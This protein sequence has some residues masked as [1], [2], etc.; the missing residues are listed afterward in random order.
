MLCSQFHQSRQEQNGRTVRLLPCRNWHCEYCQ[1]NRLRQLRAM[2]ASGAPTSCLTLTINVATG[3][4]IVDRYRLLHNAWKILV[5]RILREF[6]KPAENRWILVTDD[7]YSY[8]QPQD[9]RNTKATKAGSIHR[10]HYM[11]FPEETEN[12]QPHLHILLRTKYI[13]QRWIAQQMKDLINSPIVWIEKIKGPAGAIAYVTKY[14][15]TAP[16]Q[17]GKS[18]RYWCSRFYQIIG[19]DRLVEPLYTRINSTTIKM[20]FSELVRSIVIKG[21]IALPQS[22]KELRILSITDLADMQSRGDE[23]VSP[24]RLV[25]A[26]LWLASWRQQC[27]I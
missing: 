25:S 18:K 17:F 7:G 22:Q 27:R 19:R 1:P 14:V 20:R 13:P 11:A 12:K 10:L 4:S 15:T 2:A 3:E 5:K 8:Q 24:D 21:Q 23:A 6:K 26:Y 9:Y 16:A